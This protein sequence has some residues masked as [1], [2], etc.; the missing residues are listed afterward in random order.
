M[1]ARIIPTDDKPGA[2]E[3]GAIYFIDNVLGTSR[4]E[5]LAPMREGLAAL[6]ASAR[7]TY[8]AS[9]F[10]ELKPAEQ[11]ALLK[12]IETTPF[13]ATMR[14]L[15]IAGTFSLPEYG[16]NRN[17]IGWSLLGFEMQHMYHAPYGYYDA[18]YAREGR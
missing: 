4:A 17:G 7:T 15:T 3:A 12:N 5:A 14:L 16:G 18:E 9:A 1:A 8:G 10:R 11:D 6:Q 2:T 13:F